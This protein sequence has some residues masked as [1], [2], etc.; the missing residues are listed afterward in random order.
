MDL[1]F[2]R[3]PSTDRSKTQHSEL[4]K[5]IPYQPTTCPHRN[6]IKCLGPTLSLLFAVGF[7]SKR[8]RRVA[9]D[10]PVT[11]KRKSVSQLAR[12]KMLRV[13]VWGGM[14]VGIFIQIFR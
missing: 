13:S 10:L 9:S 8:S 3:S 4:I 2:K 7:V 11:T 12:A 5:Y 14:M 6:H 1:K